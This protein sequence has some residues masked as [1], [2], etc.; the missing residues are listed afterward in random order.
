M[1]R[2]KLVGVVKAIPVAHRIVIGVAIVIL[3]LA[4]KLFMGWSSQP[5]YTVLS[6]GLDDK[7]LASVINELEAQGVPY[8]IEAGGTRILVPQSDLA[9]TRAKLAEAGV[10]GGVEPQGYEILKDQGLSMSDAMQQVNFRR[11]LE[12]ELEKALMAM[13][14]INTAKVQLV[15]PDE[16]LFTEDQA[17]ATAA[18]LLDTKTELTD[19]QVEAITYLVSSSVEGLTTDHITITDTKGRVLSAPGGSSGASG[20]SK[21]LDATRQFEALLTS[22][23]Q[24][25]LNGYDAQVVV[26]AD[27]NFDATHTES[28]QYDPQTQGTVVLRQDSTNENY[29]GGGTPPNG[30]VGVDGGTTTDDAA[31]AGGTSDGITNYTMQ[32]Q[33]VEN[34][35]SRVVSTIDQAP[36]KLEGLHVAVVLD[37]AATA[38][39]TP[40]DPDKIKSLVSAALGLQTAGTTPRDTIEVQSFALPQTTPATNADG[41][42]VDDSASSSSSTKKSPTSMIPQALGALVL[43]FVAFSLWRMTRKPK[44]KKA[45]KVKGEAGEALGAGAGLALGAGGDVLALDGGYLE[46]GSAAAGDPALMAQHA[47]M[48]NLRD[49]VIDLV[50]RQPEEIAVLL[51][52]WLADRR[53]ETR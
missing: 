4:A 17:P 19:T 12:G 35:V 40:P 52:G 5:S 38:G 10:G 30:I 26:K 2:D 13:D 27:L 22:D 1:N 33:T 20:T 50:Q 47:A 28:E 45:K 24:R 9:T 7:E 53:A 44:A 43:A 23:V 25:L 21:N 6:S 11:A 15:V 14:G 39:A 32:K 49:D 46:L 41:T 48:D 31:A 37:S 18:V 3:V 36:G 51:R 42:P 8:K 34:G 16:K 29:T